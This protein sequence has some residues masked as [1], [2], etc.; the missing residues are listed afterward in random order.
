M[1]QDYF[2]L[3]GKD[4]PR[5]VVKLTETEIKK[6]N[7]SNHDLVIFKEALN[8]GNNIIAIPNKDIPMVC[9]KLTQEQTVE[10]MI[11]HKYS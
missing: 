5:L 1:E 7:T 8:G 10:H 3:H 4:G 11:M 2:I 9:R 6:V